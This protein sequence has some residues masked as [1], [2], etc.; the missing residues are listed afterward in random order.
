M[1]H[2]PGDWVTQPP[3]VEVGGD[4]RGEINTSKDTETTTFYE[5]SIVPFDFLSWVGR[6][7]S[8]VHSLKGGEIIGLSVAFNDFDV[9]IESDSRREISA[10]SFICEYQTGKPL[11]HGNADY[12]SDCLLV[13]AEEEDVSQVGSCSWGQIKSTFLGR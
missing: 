5:M 1:Y 12:F 8:K 4:I 13:H 11:K 9:Y 2:N 7:Y 10:E 6:E 3:W